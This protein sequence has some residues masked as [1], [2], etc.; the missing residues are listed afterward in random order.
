MKRRTKR[1][2]LLMKDKSH[3]T[4]ISRRSL[5]RPTRWLMDHHYV[6]DHPYIT[7]LDYGC[8]KCASVNPKTWHNYDPYYAPNGISPNGKYLI[9]ICNY[10]LCVKTQRER[11]KILRKIRSLLCKHGLAYISVRNDKPKKGWGC[12][13]RGTYQGRCQK[14]PLPFFYSTSQFRIYL[15][16]KKTKLP[17]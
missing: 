10:V 13:S 17:Y 5:P 12:S 1:L 11:I 8:G 7:T 2:L 6:L 9:I 14:L 4:A 15:L 3:L 16:T